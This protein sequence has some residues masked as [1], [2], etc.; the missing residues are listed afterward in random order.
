MKGLF[1]ISK[2]NKKY[3]E[4]Q[5]SESGANRHCRDTL[6]KLMSPLISIISLRSK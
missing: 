5:V 1:V 3:Y 4:Q 2:V 6:L